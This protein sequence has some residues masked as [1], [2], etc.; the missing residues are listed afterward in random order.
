VD[1]LTNSRIQHD[2]KYH[3][4]AI[5]SL[6]EECKRSSS[7]ANSRLPQAIRDL[8]QVFVPVDHQRTLADVVDEIKS[9]VETAK[10]LY[11]SRTVDVDW[12][13]DGKHP[14]MTERLLLD[15]SSIAFNI[16]MNAFRHSPEGSAVYVRIQTLQGTLSCTVR[17]HRRHGQPT[18]DAK[19]IRGMDGADNAK[20]G[21]GRQLIQEVAARAGVVVDT[22]ETTD[23]YTVSMEM[24]L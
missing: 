17:N 5:R 10:A 18:D 11:P 21:R 14:D 1:S 20:H 6:L 23:S 4:S 3:L 16:I 13:S 2:V 7:S 8:K 12:D 9:H 19:I 24:K 15:V 22:V